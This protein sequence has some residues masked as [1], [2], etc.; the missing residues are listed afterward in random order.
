MGAT[1]SG[2]LVRAHSGRR[3]R[4]PFTPKTKTRRDW[5]RAGFNSFAM[6][7]FGGFALES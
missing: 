6:P 4:F 3:L 5:L 1:P 7:L 2:S